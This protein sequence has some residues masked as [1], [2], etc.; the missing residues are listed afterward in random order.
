[1]QENTEIIEVELSAPQEAFMA[2][3]MAIMLNMAGQGSGKSHLIG[4]I[5]GYL[6]SNFPRVRGFIGANT[7]DQLSGATL[8]KSYDVWREIYGFTEYHKDS[9]PAGSFVADRKPPPH[10]QR[11]INLKSYKNVISF[12]NG[13]VV[14]VGSLENYE[15]QDGKE[16]GWAE[17]DE[18]KDTKEEAVKDVILGR[19]RQIGLWFDALGELFY[20]SSIADAQ[21]KGLTAWNPLHIHTSPASGLVTWVN[22]WFDLEQYR[23]DIKAKCQA[24]EKDFFFLENQVKRTA[25]IIYSAYHNRH[26]LAPG[27]FEIREANMS[28]EKS[29]K[30]I[31]GYPFSKSGGEYFPDF[32]Q[33]VHV[34]ETPFLPASPIHLTWDF[35]VVPYMTAL[36][37]QIK[38][39]KRFIGPGNM[40]VDSPAIGFKGIDVMQLRF[41]KEYC[42]ESP[43]NTTEAIC[44]QFE[45]DHE[46]NDLFFYGD[47]SG[48]SRIPGLGSASNFGYIEE[49]LA[50]FLTT[51]SN[52]VKKPNV[53][54]LKRRDLMNNIFAGRIPEVEIVID[55]SC[56]N[57]IKDFEK[58]K[59]GVEGKVKSEKK[60]EE[61]GGKYQEL[62]HT[63]DAAEYVVCVVA[64]DYMK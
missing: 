50:E 19:L 17:L 38:F 7:Y 40:K 29:L 53:A 35:N 36:C 37:L 5:T 6:I 28:A 14:F 63:S 62:G 30:L 59:L 48:A 21:A 32:N 9:N 39:V 10:F 31:D 18:T 45:A 12:F 26:N 46:L 25:A 2:C 60:D 11:F 4:L 54:V 41:Y 27:Y 24:R 47:A 49:A 20:N 56:E 13:C 61:T 58:C 51:V 42:L 3:R 44:L 43:R 15:A 23:D 52:R 8:K 22:D 55:P 33:L 1:V 64:V 57:L 34:K 16:Y